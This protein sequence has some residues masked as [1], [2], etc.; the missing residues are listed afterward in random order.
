MINQLL[1]Y[2]VLSTSSLHK[3]YD[4]DQGIIYNVPSNTYMI[5]HLDKKWTKKTTKTFLYKRR[6]NEKR[7]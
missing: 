6:K 4:A 7:R 3:V 1:I 2:G 5:S